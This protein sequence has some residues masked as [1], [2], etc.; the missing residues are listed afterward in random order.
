MAPPPRF[1][2]ALKPLPFPKLSAIPPPPPQQQLRLSGVSAA[3]RERGRRHQQQRLPSQRIRQTKA[4]N[5]LRGLVKKLCV[6]RSHRDQERENSLVS[7]P[8]QAE[9]T[10]GN[11]SD[12]F[13]ITLVKTAD[14]NFDYFYSDWKM[15]GSCLEDNQQ[16]IQVQDYSKYLTFQGINCFGIVKISYPYGI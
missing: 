9:M 5:E 14:V 8:A 3:P 13:K 1:L 7:K 6:T 16:D 11:T 2:S 10:R 15:T 4:K 12:N